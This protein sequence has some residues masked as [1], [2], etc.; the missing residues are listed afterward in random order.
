[1]HTAARVVS[2][3]T[4]TS[5]LHSHL[6]K[7]KTYNSATSNVLTTKKQKALSSAV[8]KLSVHLQLL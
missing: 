2:Y 8:K 1:M 5:S 4:S 7:N 3:F 6:Y